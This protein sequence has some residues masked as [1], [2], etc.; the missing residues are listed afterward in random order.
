M[1][2]IFPRFFFVNQFYFILNFSFPR[3]VRSLPRIDELAIEAL[4]EIVVAPRLDRARIVQL[5][6]ATRPHPSLLNELCTQLL[7]D[8][9]PTPAAARGGGRGGRGSKGGKATA[10]GK[11]GELF[12]ENYIKQIINKHL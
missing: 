7:V 12:L 2:N 3:L 11:R 6:Q 1:N 10:G 4:A 9:E 8:S 5:Y